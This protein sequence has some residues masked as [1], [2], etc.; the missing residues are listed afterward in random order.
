MCSNGEFP[1]AITENPYKEK[2]NKLETRS[3]IL[4]THLFHP[5]QA[6]DLQWPSGDADKELKYSRDTFSPGDCH[7]LREQFTGHSP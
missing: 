2:N 5:H 7:P 3:V 1:S 6:G 4:K